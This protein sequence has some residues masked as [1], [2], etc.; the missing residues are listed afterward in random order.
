MRPDRLRAAVLALGLLAG[1]PALAQS[2]ETLAGMEAYNH[3]D[4]AT[5]FRR[6]S[7][8]AARGDA[9]AMV[10]LGYLYTQ[11]QGVARDS[12]AALG[13]YR[14]SAARRSRDPALSAPGR[15]C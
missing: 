10:N 9:E 5:A 6:L 2:A 1:P 11:G 4:Y 8:A 14:Q 3:G 15:L 13:L 12:D 7:D